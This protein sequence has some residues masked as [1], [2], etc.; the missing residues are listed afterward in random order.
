VAVAGRGMQ[1][2]GAA[3]VAAKYVEP[4]WSPSDAVRRN[5]PELPDVIPGGSPNNPMGARA[6]AL[7]RPEIAIH[8]A[9]RAMRASIGTT[10][11]YGCIRIGNDDVTDLLDRVEPGAPAMLTP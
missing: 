9:T 10:A 7:D 11:P 1:W 5:H 2:S 4:A 8:G 3:R 6:R